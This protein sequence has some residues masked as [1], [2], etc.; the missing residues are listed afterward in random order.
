MKH[1]QLALISIFVSTTAFANVSAYF[2]QN[3]ENWYTDPYRNIS[4]PGDNLEEVIVSEI[5]QARKSVYVAVQELRLPNIARALIQKKNEGVDVRII[6]EN[7]YNFTVLTQKDPDTETEYEASKSQEL[8]AFVDVNRDGRISQEELETRDAIH[9]LRQANIPIMDDTFDM[10]R[11]AGLMHHKFVVIDGKSV[12]I[13]TA[14][15]TMSCIHGDVLTPSSRGNA[16][17]LILVQSPN[18]SK[19]FTDEFAQLWGNGKRGNFGQNKTYRGQLTSVVKGTKLTVQFSPTSRRYNWEE[20]VNGLIASYLS[21]ATKSIKAALFVF[22][23]QKLADVMQ[24]RSNAGAQIGVIIEPKFAY[25]D[26]SELLDLMGLEMLN[27]KCHYEADNNPWKIPA[28]EVGMA[29]LPKGDV[30][31]H[32]FAVVDEKTVVVGSQ[33]WSDAAN[34][35][36]DETLL[37]I[38]DAK[39]AEKFTR[40]YNRIKNSAIL[41]PQPWLLEKI[42]KLESE[43]ASLGRY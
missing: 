11:G 32:K 8:R 7:E 43:C 35:I 42:Q 13:S 25:R 38:Q 14:N 21:R 34:Y 3:T 20:S 12:I 26:Y 6:L 37:V 18:F 24:K 40:E 1:W 30:L 10:S 2:N 23:D 39:I 29:N 31:H 33:N 41:G 16:N 27:Q 4:R 15:F 19:F 28:R 22:S 17:S 9:M 5:K 36:N